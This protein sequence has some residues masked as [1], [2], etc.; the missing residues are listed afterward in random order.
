[1]KLEGKGAVGIVFK[2]GKVLIDLRLM[3]KTGVNLWEFPGGS[4][5]QGESLEDAVKRE[6]FEE[7]GIHAKKVVWLGAKNHGVHWGNTELEHYFLVEEFSGEPYPKS[8][9]EVVDIKWVRP[10]ELVDFLNL[11]WRVID[12]MY[13]L[14]RVYPQYAKVYERLLALD[15]RPN[16]GFVYF[17]YSHTISTWW[18]EHNL[19]PSEVFREEEGKIKELIRNYSGPVLEIGPGYGR[20]TKILLDKFDHVDLVEL[21]PDFRFLLA[22]KFGEKISF[23]NGLAEKFDAT[24]KYKTIVAIETIAHVKD[25]YSFIVNVKKSLDRGGIFLVS[26]DNVNSDWRRIRDRIGRIFFSKLSPFYLKIK[27]EYLLSLLEDAGFK[28]EVYPIGYEYI[29]SLP[30]RRF[31]IPLPQRKK[32]KQPYLFLIAA[33]LQ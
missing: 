21:N 17:S 9:E 16:L 26:I 22:Q 30:I 25:I 7:L 20:I 4:I 24:K 13:F 8:K 31:N 18:K 32:K 1:M 10:E 27:L 12:G 11:S 19:R 6:L 33:K 15:T 23:L 5:E 29:V 14:S 2:D 28:T 3:Q